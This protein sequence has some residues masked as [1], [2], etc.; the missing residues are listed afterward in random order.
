MRSTP[1][2]RRLVDQPWSGWPAEQVAQRGNLSWADLQGSDPAEGTDMVMG[3][4]RVGPGQHLAPHR[5]SQPETY[6][7][8]SGRGLVTIDGQ[9]HVIEAQT[10]VFI[11]GDALHQVR[12]VEA[13]DFLFLYTFAVPDF[14]QVHYRF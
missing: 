9:T 11:P 12:N 3:V 7:S 14:D 10:M 5:H 4:A 8:L 1:L 13:E 2:I 6:Y